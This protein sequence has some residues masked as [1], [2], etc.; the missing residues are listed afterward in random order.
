ML[1]INNMDK[2]VNDVKTVTQPSASRTGTAGMTLIE[3]LMAVAIISLMAA[4]IYLGGFAVLRHAQSVTIVTA[5]NLYAKEGLEEV[6]SYGYDNLRGGNLPSQEIMANPET[7]NVALVR[8]VNVIWHAPDGST[9]SV[10]L[11][12]G[13]AEAIARVTWQIRSNT[14]SVVI[15]T[16][17]Y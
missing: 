14:A 11:D 2:T 7:H 9:N 8:N 1:T 6:A 15:S 3:V 12:L 17:V 4:A 13:Y 16:L 5:A 10:G